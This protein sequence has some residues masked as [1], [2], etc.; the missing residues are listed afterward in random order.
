MPISGPN[1][2]DTESDSAGLV[3]TEGQEART[4]LPLHQAARVLKVQPDALRKRIQRGKLEA[5]KEDG[6]WRVL[7]DTTGRTVPA[8][9]SI[10]PGQ[11]RSDLIDR[12]QELS[13]QLGRQKAIAELS[14]GSRREAEEQYKALIAELQHERALLE[15]DKAAL[16]AQ[17]NELQRR[18][19]WWRRG[20]RD[21]L[22]SV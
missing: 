2:P 13:E 12:L 18:R 17:V 19:P 16:E 22:G 11:S 14:E 8:P 3:Q 6:Q 4:F 9:V 15:Q 7:V 21:E 20:K 5:Y 1:A 10:G